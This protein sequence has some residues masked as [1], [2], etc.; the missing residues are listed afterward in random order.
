[1][2]PLHLDRDEAHLKPTNNKEMFMLCGPDKQ[3]LVFRLDGC[4]VEEVRER[5]YDEKTS[6]YLVVTY[7]DADKRNKVDEALSLLFA[8]LNTKERPEH[9]QSFCYKHD[10]AL[11]IRNKG[12]EP[13]IERLKIVIQKILLTFSDT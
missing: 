13:D 7:K 2:N 11:K 4:Q 5:L 10:L 1:M 9:C 3:E 12:N 8:Q 6:L